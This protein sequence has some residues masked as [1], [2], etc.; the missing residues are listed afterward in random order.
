MTLRKVNI[1]NSVRYV[2]KGGHSHSERAPAI[3]SKEG[4][5]KPSTRKKNDSN[6]KRSQKKQ[7]LQEKQNTRRI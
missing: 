3:I 4:D 2:S 6:I 5:S 1:D 7:K